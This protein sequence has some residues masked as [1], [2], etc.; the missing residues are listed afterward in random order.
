MKVNVNL[1]FERSH[2]PDQF[3]TPEAVR[4]IATMLDRS[5]FES[6]L[7]TDHPAPS[8]RW[9]DA[10]GHHAPDPFVLLSLIASL[11]TRIRLQTG[12]LVLAYR[13]PFITARSVSTLDTFSKGRVTL[14]VGAGYLKGEYKALGVDFERRN[15]IMDEYILAMKAA[16]T[17][18]EFSFEGTG[19]S[20]RGN[21]ILP[22][23]TQKPHP[24]LLI[25][26]NSKRAIRRVVDL[27]DGWNP[28]FATAAVVQ[29]TRTAAVET[30]EDLAEALVYLRDYC[31]QTGRETP[32]AI[33]IGSIIHPGDVFNA[34][35]LIDRI[36]QLTEM[37]VEGCATHF[38]GE[39]RAE[40]CDRVQQFDEEVLAKL[41]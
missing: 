3:M 19:Y 14:S 37:G 4:E 5:R 38:D 18:E 29:T 20:A 41:G 40:W 10:G 1:P 30:D 2:D 8:G 17:N 31:A 12:I 13:N 9:L 23:P 15:E 33:I 35:A 28:Y 11:T 27:A 25:G 22:L 24:P 6:V 34:Q 32:P 26:G 7:V 21:R 39:K 16:W 36:G